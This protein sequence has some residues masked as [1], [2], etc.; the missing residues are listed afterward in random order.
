MLSYTYTK[1]RQLERPLVTMLSR[2]LRIKSIVS[3]DIVRAE[4]SLA[5]MLVEAIF[6]LV[7]FI[8]RIQ[9]QPPV[10]L[11]RHLDPYTRSEIVAV[12]IAL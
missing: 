5:L 3:H 8:H 2:Q 7:V 10:K 9:S 12:S 1:C 11:L 6:Q 4:F